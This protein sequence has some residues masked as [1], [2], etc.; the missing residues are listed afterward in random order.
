MIHG[1][2]MHCDTL[3]RSVMTRFKGECELPDMFKMDGMVDFD[4]LIKAEAMCQFFAVFMLP[5]GAR[6][7]HGLDKDL[8]DQVHIQW[9]SEILRY[10]VEKYSDK[11]AMAYSA[12]DIRRN[13]LNGKVSAMLTIEDSRAVDN[14]LENIKKFYDLGY[15][16][17]G[18]IWNNENCLAYPNAW[19]EEDMMKGL[20]PFG[21]EAVQYME[22]LG[23][24]VDCSHLNFGGFDDLCDILKKPFVATHSNAMALSPHKRNLDDSRLK[25][26]AAKGGCTGLNFG[27]EFLNQKT[28]TPESNEACK[29]STAFL[30]AEHARH[31][32]DVAGVDTVALGTDFD[33]IRGNL[34]VDSPDKMWILEREFK[35]HGFTEAEIDK[36][37]Y[38]NALR[39]LDEVEG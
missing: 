25:K 13:F 37:A 29:D 24:V 22:E 9:G 38:G 23:I 20:K 16:V 28:Q 14:K 27:A 6:R 1:V 12:K 39:V 18:V 2:D 36:I 8:D 31:L 26:L 10:N 5:P 17:M 4:R 33:G 21:K 15:R 32:A 30:I 3:N 19:A 35:R 11:M 7:F 34:E